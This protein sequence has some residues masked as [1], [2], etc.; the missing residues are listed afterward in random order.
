MVARFF[1]LRHMEIIECNIGKRKVVFGLPNAGTI[2][3]NL[4]CKLNARGVIEGAE[5]DISAIQDEIKYNFLHLKSKDLFPIEVQS[6]SEDT[7]NLPAPIFRNKPKMLVEAKL[8]WYKKL[9]KELQD[10]GLLK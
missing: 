4:I 5:L 9:K 8:F 7:I 1:G 10:K 2:H 3:F 6:S